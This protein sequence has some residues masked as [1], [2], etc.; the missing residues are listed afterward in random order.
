M[1]RLAV[2]VTLEHAQIAAGGAVVITVLVAFNVVVFAAV[3][4]YVRGRDVTF[5]FR[6]RIP[7]VDR[8][9]EHGGALVTVRCTAPYVAGVEAILRQGGGEVLG[10]AEETV[11]PVPA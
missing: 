9:L 8:A 5:P 1:G 2:R 3:L 10:F 4:A 6:E 7:D 11:Y